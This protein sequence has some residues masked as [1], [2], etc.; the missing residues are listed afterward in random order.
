MTDHKEDGR[1]V[2][3]IVLKESGCPWCWEALEVGQAGRVSHLGRPSGVGLTTSLQG[4]SWHPCLQITEDPGRSSS[5]Q[6]FRWEVTQSPHAT[7]PATPRDRGGWPG[8]LLL[9]GTEVTHHAA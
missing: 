8:P 2:S 3:V 9:R 7:F 4:N 6:S 1:E 5:G